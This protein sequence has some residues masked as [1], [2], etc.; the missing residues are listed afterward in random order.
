M[1]PV[2]AGTKGSTYGTH[3]IRITGSPEMIDAVLSNIKELLDAE[4][5]DTRIEISRSAIKNT[6]HFVNADANAESCYIKI[7]KRKK[8]RTVRLLG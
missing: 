3:Q 8:E 4:N 5:K 2:P 7:R 6:D 1:K